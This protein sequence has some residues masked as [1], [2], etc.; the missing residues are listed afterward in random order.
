[1]DNSFTWLIQPKNRNL[2][3]MLVDAGFEVWL[4]NHR[5][6]KYSCEHRCVHH[7]VHT[8]TSPY[9]DFSFDEMALHDTTA[10]VD[11]VLR[12]TGQEQVYYIA[13]S[14]G[15]L[16]L[17]GAATLYPDFPKKI[18][19]FVALGPAMYV[20]NMYSPLMAPLVR[21]PLV[22]LLYK[23]NLNNALLFPDFC[24]VILRE[25]V[26]RFP[27]VTWQFVETIAGFT[28]NLQVDLSRMAVMA[29]NEP[30]GTSMKNCL[31]WMQMIRTGEYRR[32]DYGAKRNMQVYGQEE[33]PRY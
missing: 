4:T 23:L 15:S 21:I 24:S 9:W 29:R 2:A 14:Q 8:P 7:S 32:F 13:H 6:N 27:S 26:L 17:F 3:F 20:K 33:A 28:V 22:D 12:T 1:M 18:K 16:T 5:G 19:A 11:Y 31:H 25:L 30:G 10:N